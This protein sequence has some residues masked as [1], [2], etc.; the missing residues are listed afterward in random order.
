MTASM[1]ITKMII[2]AV[3]L[4]AG[5]ACNSSAAKNSSFTAAQNEA[6]LKTARENIERF[7]KGDARLRVMSADGKP[8][9]AAKISVRQIA[10]DFKFGC[11][12]K[13]DDL[14]P[15]KLPAY[16]QNFKRLFNFAVVGTYWDFIENEKGAE[17]WEWFERE[18]ALAQKMNLR[19]E[20]APVLWGTHEAGTPK[21]LPTNADALDKIL[22]NHTQTVLQ[23]YG[24]AVEDWEIV[25]EPLAPKKD[26]FAANTDTDYVAGAFRTARAAAPKARLLIN[27]YG[28]FG[29]RDEANYNRDKY[30]ERL[31]N[32]IEEKVLFDAIGIQAHAGGEWFAPANVAAQLN[33]YAALGKPLQITEFS[34]QTLEYD[35]RKTALDIAGVYQTGTWTAEKQ[36]EFYREFYTVAF[37]SLQVE[38]ITTWG[39]DD[40][41]TWLPGIGLIDENGNPKPNYAMLD[42]LINNEWHTNLELISAADG[43]ADFRG[44]Y[45]KYE[46]TAAIGDKQAAAVFDLQKTNRNGWVIV[47]K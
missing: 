35:D 32:L 25:N 46:I 6:A 45:G 7:R 28:V 26:F 11:Y 36:A 19:V 27:E 38:A 43:S 41:R 14:A 5:A 40:E 13:I 12:L 42:R 16:E 10:H 47:V 9:A 8:I 31:E 37:G 39:L 1:K 33:R 2:A 4:L 34:A 18:L 23:K 30:F 21:W 29:N 24:G 15:E 44:F 17:N 22:E 20:A 3:C